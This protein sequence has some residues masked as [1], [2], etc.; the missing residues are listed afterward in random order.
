M[1]WKNRMA[2]HKEK[3]IHDDMKIHED[4]KNLRL[5]NSACLRTLYLNLL[6]LTKPRKSLTCRITIHKL[7]VL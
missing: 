3:K 1:D 4:T 6:R 2:R 5:Q 7:V